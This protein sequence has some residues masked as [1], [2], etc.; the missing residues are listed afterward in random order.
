MAVLAP[1]SMMIEVFMDLLQPRFM[2]S[3]VDKGIANG[4]IPYIIK[5]GL[6]MILIAMVG[7]AG[8]MGATYFSSIASQNFGADLRLDIFKKVQSFSF[9]S[10]D[11]FRTASL[12]TRLTNDVMQIQMA[13]LFMLRMLVRAPLL[14]IGGIVMAVAI[15]VRLSAIILIALPLLLLTTVFVIR[16]GFPL[17]T[18]VQEK[19]DRVN[20]VMQENLAGV[21]VVKAFVRSEYEKGRFAKA[22]D[23]LASIAIKASRIVGASMPLSMLIMNGAVIAIVW[24]GGIRV[25]TGDMLVGEVM[26]YIT[27]VSQILFSFMMLTFMFTMISRAKASADRITEVLETEGEVPVE[28][29][30]K[31]AFGQESDIQ[32]MHEVAGSTSEYTKPE[33]EYGTKA[34]NEDKAE[35]GIELEKGL[36]LKGRVDFVNVSFKYKDATGDPVLKNITF[37]AMPG[38]TVAIIGPTGSGKSTLVNLIPRFYEVSEGSILIDG[39]DIRDMELDELRKNIGI[40]LQES[41]LFT[42]TIMDNIRWGREEASEEEVIDAAKAAQ[43]HNFIMEFPDKYNTILGQRGVNVSGGQ[44]QRLSIAR[45]LLKKPAILI[46]DDS[47]SA[48]DLETEARI[49]DALRERIKDCTCFII[50]Q[51]ISSV[52]HADKIIVLD[53][54]KIVDIGSHEELMKRCRMYQDIYNSQ[55]GGR[56]VAYEQ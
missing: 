31:E 10:I 35:K 33:S 25:N 53:D 6:L 37:T 17:F 23:D 8:G 18:K 21:R 22:N 3:I 49:Q 43:A 28:V 44:K 54:G 24:F 41:I 51:R 29:F 42:G 20:T 46:L 45:A 4:D 27:Y 2:E 9:D 40:V 15:N 16:K 7:V 50:A 47:T 52:M 32:D 39:I 26:A 38:E 19:L 56:M 11:K 34:E 55:V 36:R 5:T 1:L 12:V 30:G 48:V 14:C 13:V